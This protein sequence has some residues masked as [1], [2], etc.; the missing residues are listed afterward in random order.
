MTRFRSRKD[1]VVRRETMG[2]NNVRRSCRGELCGWQL[3]DAGS[4]NISPRLQEAQINGS[5]QL[6]R[7]P[8]FFEREK[9]SFLLNGE[10]NAQVSLSS[11]KEW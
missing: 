8:I 5:T 1:D 2:L 9:D 10:E 11:S 6:F 7:N 4:G 3:H